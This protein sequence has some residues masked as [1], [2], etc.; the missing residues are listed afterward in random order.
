MGRAE[1]DNRGSSRPSASSN[2]LG[3]LTQRIDLCAHAE[4]LLEPDSAAGGRPDPLVADHVPGA[5]RH[6]TWPECSRGR[7][8]VGSSAGPQAVGAG[9]VDLGVGDHVWLEQP[10]ALGCQDG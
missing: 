10:G 5:S 3:D 2:L 1:L 8:G 6:S 9:V 7:R 4:D